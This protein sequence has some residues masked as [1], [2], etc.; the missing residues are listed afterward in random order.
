[1]AIIVNQ[2]TDVMTPVTGAL[3][4]VGNLV[5]PKANTT[6]IKVDTASPTYAWADLLGPIIIRG[7]GVNDPSFSTFQNNLRAYQFAVN[8][9]VELVFHLGHDYAIGTDIYIHAHWAHNSASVASGAVTWEFES[10][11]AKGHNQAAFPASVITT[12]TQNASTTQY[13]H[14]IAE[15]VISV[16]GGSG[17]LLNSTNFEP[18]GLILVRARLTANTISAATSPFAFLFD[19]HYQTSGIPGTKQKAPPFWT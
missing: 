13:Q 12:V 17:T 15:T 3:A 5:L 7:T 18:D 4:V 11:Y 19:C 9:F 16:A 14:M 2:T 1:M 8:D 10:A 6:C